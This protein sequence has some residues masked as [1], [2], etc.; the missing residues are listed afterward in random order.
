[1]TANELD[2][3]LH[4]KITQHCADGDVLAN[5]GKHEDAVTEFNKAWILVPDPNGHCD[6]RHPG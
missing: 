4:A 6:E 3:N 2:A 1:M 5:Q